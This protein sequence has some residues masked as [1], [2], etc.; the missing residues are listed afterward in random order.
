M[1]T[2]DPS[3]LLL[4]LQVGTQDTLIVSEYQGRRNA[5]TARE[6][7]GYGLGLM[8]LR[9]MPTYQ[10]SATEIKTIWEGHTDTFIDHHDNG[11]ILATPEER[12]ILRE[13]REALLLQRQRERDETHV[14]NDAAMRVWMDV[15][16]RA[17][18]YLNAA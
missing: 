16:M 11:I 3:K 15:G 4:P 13:I 18:Q 7:I 5:S 17:E 6:A 2:Q 1:Q 12:E 14:A 9:L 8:E 10:N